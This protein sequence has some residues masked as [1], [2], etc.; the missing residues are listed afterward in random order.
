ME[1][2]S[3]HSVVKGDIHLMATA[4]QPCTSLEIIPRH[5]RRMIISHAP[6]YILVC[7]S[8]IILSWS[9]KTHQTVSG[10]QTKIQSEMKEVNV[11]LKIGKWCCR[12]VFLEKPEKKN[13]DGQTIEKWAVITVSCALISVNIVENPSDVERARVSVIPC[14]MPTD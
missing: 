10:K 14:V 3:G 1:A 7:I 8:C 4:L 12:N 11:G 9:I 6:N 5:Q 13:F 2:G